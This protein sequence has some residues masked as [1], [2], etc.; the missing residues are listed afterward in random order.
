MNRKK[1]SSPIVCKCNEVPKDVIENAIRNGCD[2]LNK[3]FDETSAGVGA[4]GGSCRRILAP[5]LESYLKTGKFPGED[6]PSS[7]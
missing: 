4:C 2:T 5:M 3:I 7:Q 6:P 1:P